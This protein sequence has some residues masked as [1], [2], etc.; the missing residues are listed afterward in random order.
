MQS[1]SSVIDAAVF[2][3]K[4]EK[5]QMGPKQKEDT[6]SDMGSPI[7][8][9]SKSVVDDS[10]KQEGTLF[11]IYVD[12]KKIGMMKSNGN[13]PFPTDSEF[14]VVRVYDYHNEQEKR[15]A[16]ENCAMFMETFQ[17]DSDLEEFRQFGNYY[18]IDGKPIKIKIKKQII[19]E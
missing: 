1:T 16:L 13:T 14:R 3:E 4:L 15:T 9:D 7:K 12:K 6:P 2:K 10:N 19:I 5:Y 11:I 17:N 8:E 18:I